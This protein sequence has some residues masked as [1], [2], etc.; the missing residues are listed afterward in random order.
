MIREPVLSFDEFR[1]APTAVALGRPR[2]DALGR[3][4]RRLCRR[5]LCDDGRGTF[6]HHGR[7]AFAHLV[8]AP[9]S[10]LWHRQAAL[11]RRRAA[12][13]GILDL[14]SGLIDFLLPLLS[15]MLDSCFR[16]PARSL[17]SW[18]CVSG[19]AVA[20]I[21]RPIVEM[22]SIVVDDACDH[23]HP[24]SNSDGIHGV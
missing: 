5:K 11:P 6:L 12:V 7:F 17:T 18:P 21:I 24:E 22:F 19:Y 23:R 3:G 4:D 10:A 20:V 9:R 14:L 1:S 13:A 2:P 8:L 16:L 15:R